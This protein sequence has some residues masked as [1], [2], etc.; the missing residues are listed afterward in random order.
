MRRVS[1]RLFM[2]ALAL[3]GAR[4][5]RADVCSS[6]VS[7]TLDDDFKGIGGASVDPATRLDS[8][9]TLIASGTDPWTLTLP[10]QEGDFSPYEGFLTE[11]VISVAT[12][13]FD[14]DANGYDDLIALVQKINRPKTGGSFPSDRCRLY[15]FK[16]NGSASGGAWNFSAGQ[17]L[18]DYSGNYLS[19]DNC[20]EEGA[21]VRGGDFDGDGMV[22]VMVS[23]LEDIETYARPPLD[24]NSQRSMYIWRNC[25]SSG[26]NSAGYFYGNCPA[27]SRSP[28][29]APTFSRMQHTMQ[30]YPDTPQRHWGEDTVRLV[31]WNDDSSTYNGIFTKPRSDLLLVDSDKDKQ[32]VYIYYAC[33]DANSSG[34][35][36]SDDFNNNHG[37]G[38]SN[39]TGAGVPDRLRLI[40]NAPFGKSG[41]DNEAIPARNNDCTPGT[42]PVYGRGMTVILADDFDADGDTDL[43]LGSMSEY[44]LLF[45]ENTGSNGSPSFSNTP[46]STISFD[47]GGPAVGTTY[48]YNLDG[49]PDIVVATNSLGCNGSDGTVWML[50]NDGAGGFPY[51]PT[52]LADLGDNVDWLVNLDADGDGNQDILAGRKAGG[53]FDS[54]GK[55]WEGSPYVLIKPNQSTIYHSEGTAI[56]QVPADGLVSGTDS[57][58]EVTLS[59]L[60]IA[61]Q[62]PDALRIWVSNNDGLVWEE[63]IDAEIPAPYGTGSAVH[64][65]NT[66][67]AKLRWKVY[68][69]YEENLTAPLDRWRPGATTSPQIERIK[70]DYKATTEAYNITR[71]QLSYGI[72]DISGSNHE[73]LYR[74]Y[75]ELPS[76]KAYVDA[77]DITSCGTFTGAV[78]EDA[79][80][81]W[82][83]RN[84]TGGAD[85]AE[86]LAANAGSSRVLYTANGSNALVGTVGSGIISLGATERT[87]FNLAADGSEDSTFAF[88]RDGMTTAVGSHWRM[89]DI[90]HSSPIAVG[91]PGGQLS[92]TGASPL[93]T[94]Y[95][96]DGSLGYQ[97]FVDNNTSRTPIVYIGSNDGVLHA[98]NALDG[99][100]EWG[101]IPHNL[102]SKIKQQRSSTDEYAHNYFVDGPVV[103]RDVY[104]NNTSSW[105]TVLISGQARGTGGDGENYFFALD[106]TDPAS[107][108]PLWEFTDAW[109]Q[110]GGS[111]DGNPYE[112]MPSVSCSPT[113]TNTCDAVQTTLFVNASAGASQITI[114]AADY[115]VFPDNGI[116]ELKR[117]TPGSLE[118]FYYSKTAPDKLNLLDWTGSADTLANFHGAGEAVYLAPDYIFTEKNRQIVIEAEDFMQEASLDGSHNWTVQSST[119]GFTG[120]GYAISL[121]NDAN[122]SDN[123]TSC[124]AT[125][126]YTV[127][128][129]QTGTYDLYAYV[130]YTGGGDDSF[131]WGY[132]DN[133]LQRNRDYNMYNAWDLVDSLGFVDNN[134]TTKRLTVSSTG[135]HTI[136]MWQRESGARIDKL[137][138]VP[139]G[140]PAPASTVTGTCE[141]VCSSLACTP[142]TV[143]VPDSS[144][145]DPANDPWPECPANMKCCDVPGNANEHFC[146]DASQA[147]SSPETVLGE[148]WSPPQVGKF[149][150]NNQERFLA[151]FGS[152][153][154]NRGAIN[155][156]R[157]VYA[158]DV[159]TGALVG[160]WDLDDISDATVD[161]EN[162]VPG[163]V[164]LV[165][166]DLCGAASQ[167]GCGLIDRIYVG[168]LEGRLW[169]IET[170]DNGTLGGDGLIDHA[171]W[172]DCVV[173]D[174][175]DYNNDGTRDWAPIITKPAAAVLKSDS[176]HVYFGTGGD[177][178]ADPTVTYRFY[179]VEDDDAFGAGGCNQATRH[180]SDLYTSDSEWV[181]GDGLQND[182]NPVT[183]GTA[184]ASPTDEGTANDRYWSDP[185]LI[186]GV[187]LMFF[188][189]Q[190]EVESTNPCETIGGT[191]DLYMVTIRRYRDTSG[192][193]HQPGEVTRIAG[194]NKIR[195]GAIVR[196]I[197]EGLS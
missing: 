189:L 187:V 47:K 117:A 116:I 129:D 135:Q 38:W 148:T 157:S 181:I 89:Y 144:T 91:P 53:A 26:S 107:P 63:L 131:H 186:N 185:I 190:G 179:A 23:V 147:C 71:S 4:T 109:D 62:T 37:F 34:C 123:Y 195:Q 111:C 85:A 54:G 138:L 160:Q 25:P 3:L 44:N 132:D 68:M 193:I 33:Q 151:I 141:E 6:E 41:D 61:N 28:G 180:E 1:I 177:D 35:D 98:F 184:L 58:A 197:T 78:D 118:A 49:Y 87:I 182:G 15:F 76:F 175:G 183:A 81:D 172:P 125:T 59:A 50:A 40:D 143:Q 163:G 113:C 92:G 64:N 66:S 39:H 10:L 96:P 108:K 121:P 7:K 153:Y 130:Y 162:S 112:Y 137:I 70:L 167:P 174:A 171:K 97:T 173:F 56:S 31:S 43:I 12:G 84:G 156:G 122:C 169:K 75:T 145:F 29:D 8:A 13:N 86:Q 93:T 168:D 155:V 158:V 178:R 95:D 149:L 57:I 16:N 192:H 32:D 128:F 152:G 21:T 46:T 2:V 72:F 65:F 18:R 165:D 126:R 14:N 150:V 103:V 80:V 79:C 55:R 166:K 142:S 114:D 99:G 48:D 146:A 124:G 88:V 74:A 94:F 139:Q 105:R 19:P 194:L 159:M 5:V 45:F 27:L 73:I 20:W 17:I 24:S 119:S 188:S 11:R 133:W 22:D 134:P 106:V 77:L 110:N 154:N 67:G 51:E 36:N 102:A 30:G 196:G 164:T 69:S 120:D 127:R 140:D 52:E 83:W 9:S 136:N 90:G 161:L 60:S 82:I 191:S 100:E 104:D 115:D 170:S 42:S 176:V 101:F